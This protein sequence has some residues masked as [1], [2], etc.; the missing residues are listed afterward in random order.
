MRYRGVARNFHGAWHS[1]QIKRP[2]TAGWL[3]PKTSDRLVAYDVYL[4]NTETGL[5]FTALAGY[6]TR[7]LR[8]G[9]LVVLGAIFC[10]KVEDDVEE[11]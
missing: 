6:T 7:F 9:Q 3:E 1:L 10:L 4:A 5:P 8:C 2:G 11:F